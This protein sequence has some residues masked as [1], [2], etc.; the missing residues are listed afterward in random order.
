MKKLLLLGI[1]LLNILVLY[2]NK[3]NLNGK[4]ERG[5]NRD[6]QNF[7]ELPAITENPKKFTPGTLWFKKKI[8][9]P[10]G[11]WSHA[12][13][14]LKGA[15]FSPAIYVNGMQISE[16]EGGMA[17][18]FHL[19]NHEAIKPNCDVEIEIA[20]K[21]LKDLNQKDASYIPVADHWRSNI[22]SCIWDDIILET[23]NELKFSNFIPEFNM[24]DKEFK[25]KFDVDNYSNS[26]FCNYRAELSIYDNKRLVNTAQV[27]GSES[28]GE[29]QLKLS[30]I[31]LWSPE[32]PKLYKIEIKL[33]K[34]ENLSHVENFDYGFKSIELRDKQTY[35]NG[36]LYKLR[37]GTVVWHRWMRD[38]EGRELGFNEKWFYQN[39]VKRL[40]DYGANTLRFHLGN[41]PERFIDMCDKY[42]LLIQ[43]E[44]SFFHG[45]PASEKSLLKQWPLW[46]NQGLKHASLGILHP[47]NETHG[48]QLETAWN[49]LDKILVKYPK[50]VM[51][52]R[53]ILH[54]HKYWWSLFENVGLYYDSYKEFPK[55]IMVDEFG[56][57]YL[58]GDV[59]IG[60]YKTAKSAF[61]RF[62]GTNL[63]K[64]NLLEL[65]NIANS[66]IAEYWRQIG[67]TGIS[68]FTIIGS[69]E[70]GNHWFLGDL[71]EGNPKPVWS[72][73]S[74]TFSPVAVSMN[75]WN[76]N[77]VPNQEVEIPFFFFNDTKEDVNLQVEVKILER[78]TNKVVYETDIV[79][80]VARVSSQTE[81]IKIQF[82]SKQG[83][84][85][86]IADLKNTLKG[87]NKRVWSYW[88]FRV[89]K[90]K[91]STEFLKKNIFVPKIEK[92]LLSFFEIQG[93][94]TTQNIELSD[95]AVFGINSWNKLAKS[96][97]SVLKVMKALNDKKIDILLLDVGLKDLG[98]G[99]VP[100][101]N[102]MKF[103][104][105]RRHINSPKIQKVKL[106][107]GLVAMFKDIPEP[108]SHI[109]PSNEGIVLWNN[110]QYNYNWL[111]NG[112]RGGLIVPANSMQLGGMSKNAFVEQWVEIGAEQSKLIKENY[113]AYDLQGFY[114]F[115]SMS[116]DKTVMDKLR[117]KVKFLVDDAPALSASIDP[118]AKIEIINLH[119]S[120]VGCTKEGAVK[121]TPLVKCGGSLSKSPVVE[122]DFGKNSGRVIVSQL[123]TKGRLSGKQNGK[124]YEVIEDECAKQT[125]LNM[126]NYLLTKNSEFRVK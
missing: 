61:M 13:L 50:L 25:L 77:F 59:K 2:S 5:V 71:K 43:Y 121:F 72:A 42:G 70:D 55:A 45:M 9:L 104:Q 75:I 119:E 52:D 14:I 41:P 21:S 36:E 49:A 53:D 125:V 91:I 22:S 26:D 106:I 124:I 109:H 65:Q 94:N 83:N 110:L 101:K 32:K 114:A 74:S 11:D 126:I 31:E 117:E 56:G 88:D 108:E 78:T 63:D 123:L 95:I 102:K 16:T 29:L 86:I 87:V 116:H 98:D 118:L 103:L 80:K 39:I 44:W 33:Y 85:R 73:L 76:K 90:S 35:L 4:W 30:N 82:P 93:I 27:L 48:K 99:Y 38:E 66:K 54:I 67:A 46:I 105:G 8:K 96:D 69:K 113:Y 122:V 40:K 81:N 89:Y 17:E 18:T 34:G 68:G 12:T 58:D 92:E 10:K 64:E 60:D 97:K 3:T 6:Y 23:H 28:S 15:R 37:A 57:N 62:L 111:W 79:R 1:L 115:S 19:L 100:K 112:Y 107:N 20:L 47:Y 51:A 24:Q 84:Y 7:V 120:Y